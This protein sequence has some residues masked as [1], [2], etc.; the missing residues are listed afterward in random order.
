MEAR[1]R[2]GAQWRQLAKMTELSVGPMQ[3]WCGL[4][5]RLLVPLVFFCCLPL[6]YSFYKGKKVKVGFLYTAAYTVEPEQRASQS[7]KWQLIGKGQWC[8]GAMRSIHCPC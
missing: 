3:W 7:R 2:W 8:C 1:I 4:Y 5:V 6:H